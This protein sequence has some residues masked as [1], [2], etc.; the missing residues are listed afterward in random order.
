MKKFLSL[1]LIMTILLSMSVMAI[2]FSD[3]DE[4][5][6]TD[7]VTVMTGLGIIQGD[8]NNNDG[9]PHHLS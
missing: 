4:I 8:D 9:I 7:A 2:N 1:F 3:E 6:Y 5:N